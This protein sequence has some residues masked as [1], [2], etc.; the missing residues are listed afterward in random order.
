MGEVIIRDTAQADSSLKSIA[1]RYFNP[2][3]AHPSALIGELPIGKPSILVPFITQ[4]VAGL[5]DQLT[6]FGGDYPTPDGTCIRDYIHVVDLAKAHVKALEYLGSQNPGYYDVFN[7]G[8]GH[9]SSVLEVIKTFQ[10]VTGEKV[11][12]KIGE[13]RPGDVV[14][15]YADAHK[16]AKALGWRA[17]KNLADALEDAWRWQLKSSA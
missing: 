13:R 2:I 15:A 3:G 14:V 17:E 16:A 10:D 6:V 11:P 5:H 1:L 12:Y 8:T 7:I 9:G 4:T